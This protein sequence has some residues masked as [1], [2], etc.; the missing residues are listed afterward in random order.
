MA[1]ALWFLGVAISV[2]IRR[3]EGGRLEWPSGSRLLW[4]AVIV[5]A[6][7]SIRGFQIERQAWGFA[8]ISHDGAI[9]ALVADRIASGEVSFTPVVPSHAYYRD[10]G[11]HFVTA[12]PFALFG[13]S[14][15]TV[16]LVGAL[17]VVA[18]LVLFFE[19]V[20]FLTGRREIAGVASLLYAVSP[21]DTVLAFSAYERV[22]G[23]PFLLASLFLALRSQRDD[24]RRDALWAGLSSG[25]GLWSFYSFNYI[26]AALLAV[27]VVNARHR[28]RLVWPYLEGLV[29]LQLPRALY[30]AFHPGEYMQR[31]NHFLERPE[32]F[33]SYAWT[34]VVY[35]GELLLARSTEQKWLLD[36]R[37]LLEAWQ[38]PFIAIGIVVCIR[39]I[40]EP[41]SQFVLVSVCLLVL[42]NL[43]ATVK[44]YRFINAMPL[45][46]LLIALALQTI[47]GGFRNLAL[48]RIAWGALIAVGV[49]GSVVRLHSD[50]EY[51]D[52]YGLEE[53]R[54][55]REL[56]ALPEAGNLQIVGL[57]TT[58]R[59]VFLERAWRNAD[60]REALEASPR[61]ALSSAIDAGVR[62]QLS[63]A[64]QAS[65]PL[66]IVV[67][68]GGPL[69]R[70]VTLM[71]R[72]RFQAVER[73]LSLSLV[74]GSSA[75]Y[76][77]YDL[78][79]DPQQRR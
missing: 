64:R 18:N 66:R 76:T 35:L 2:V 22:L 79:T 70:S 30:I 74:D 61:T 46:Y 10:A 25:L 59:F 58:T 63:R 56:G 26:A 8:G 13:A 4:Y 78:R 69:S 32:S 27:V 20:N 72:R 43:R 47:S 42:V 21:S 19:L 16:R 49:W 67:K 36:S 44:D 41:I 14:I 12:L 53:V 73:R 11:L 57:G 28:P 38:V 68:Q 3:R 34:H 51:P 5:A 52:H 77:I 71:L 45:L 37:P 33:M 15:E 39:R 40:R 50:R 29:L 48:R 9:N 7:V 54:L 65:G 17:L 62:E 6:A 60:L 55:A 24:S 75:T 23:T 1:A 31:L